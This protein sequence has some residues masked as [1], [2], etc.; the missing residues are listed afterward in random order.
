MTTATSGVLARFPLLLP[1]RN[2]FASYGASAV[3]RTRDRGHVAEVKKPISSGFGV[4]IRV[5]KETFLPLNVQPVFSSHHKD[6]LLYARTYQRC[7]MRMIVRTMDVRV[8][9][10]DTI[11]PFQLANGFETVIGY[12]YQERRANPLSRIPRIQTSHARCDKASELVGGSFPVR[13]SFASYGASAVTRTS[14]RE[15]VAEA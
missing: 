1:V 4:S 11:D 5:S 15:H 8:N 14:G 2:S 13:N 3:T 6:E 12:G 10:G 9:M 7:V